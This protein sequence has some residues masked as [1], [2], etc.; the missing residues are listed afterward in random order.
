VDAE[1]TKATT[2]DT[3]T[4][5]K[6]TAAAAGVRG[7]PSPLEPPS[8]PAT[9][10]GRE[11]AAAGAEATATDTTTKNT[12]TAS[13][14]GVRTGRG[15]KPR[16]MCRTGRTGTRP[17]LELTTTVP[18]YGN[19]LTGDYLG[20]VKLFEKTLKRAQWPSSECAIFISEVRMV[21]KGQN[22]SFW[23]LFQH[24]GDLRLTI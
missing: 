8:A 14:A 19:L 11:A 1:S 21:I 4:K 15:R 18:V 9:D 20:I 3:T 2:A 16:W 17:G 13:A 5:D 23:A 6:V 10:A 24:A 12:T 22:N 7:G